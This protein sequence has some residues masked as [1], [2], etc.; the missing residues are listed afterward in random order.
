M[1]VMKQLKSNFIALVCRSTIL[2]AAPTKKA[3]IHKN[4]IDFLLENM[5]HAIPRAIA[6]FCVRGLHSDAAG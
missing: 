3:S 4:I 6:Y 5:E 2:V 1:V